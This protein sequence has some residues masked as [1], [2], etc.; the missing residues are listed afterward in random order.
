[1]KEDIYHAEWFRS[2]YQLEGEYRELA[3]IIRRNLTFKNAID[4]GCGIGLVIDE[5]QKHEIPV[6][7]IDGS[8]HA[9][10]CAPEAV[11]GSIMTQDLTRMSAL[12]PVWELVIC[13]EVAEHLPPEDAD[14]LVK[15]CCAV[16]K[17]TIFFT[18]ATPGQ[19]GNDHINEQPHEYWLEKFDKKGWK[20]DQEKTD[21]IRVECVEKLKGMHWF[22]KNSMVLVH[23]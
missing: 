9:R 17:Q 15:A 21:A 18:A 10:K 14:P 5:L 2:H 11:A 1:M 6:L 7:G 19:G 3:Q 13:T 23:K 12:E 20:V 22:G 16:A 4:L 8:V